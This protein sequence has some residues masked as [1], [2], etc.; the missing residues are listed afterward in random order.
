ML[1]QHVCFSVLFSD[2]MGISFNARERKVQANF[3]TASLLNQQQFV[4]YLGGSCCREPVEECASVYV[5]AI[6]CIIKDSESQAF[7]LRPAPL[8]IRLQ[9][10]YNHYIYC[11]NH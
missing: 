1:Q 4:N 2:V 9:K 6:H 8:E 5:C 10:S 7:L 11:N 3:L